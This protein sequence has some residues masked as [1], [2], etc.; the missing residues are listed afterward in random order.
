MVI[1]PI[2]LPVNWADRPSWE[3]WKGAVDWMTTNPYKIN[4]TPWFSNTT[5][6]LNITE[7]YRRWKY[8]KKKS[9]FTTP[10]FFFSFCLRSLLWWPLNALFKDFPTTGKFFLYYYFVLFPSLTKLASKKCICISVQFF[11]WL[12]LL[13]NSI[14]H[15]SWLSTLC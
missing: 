11:E 8:K 6:S 3:L 14:Y 12:E 15:Y 13:T 5:S 4:Y 7:F 10:F 9:D 1:R 2:R